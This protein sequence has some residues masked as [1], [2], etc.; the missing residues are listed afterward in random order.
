MDVVKNTWIQDIEC[1]G[2][3]RRF[4]LDVSDISTKL[5]IVVRETQIK[6]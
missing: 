4:S 3:S 2:Y 5:K 6:I 1:L